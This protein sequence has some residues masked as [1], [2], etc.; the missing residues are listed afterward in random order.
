MKALRIPVLILSIFN[1]L[2][3]FGTGV[4]IWPNATTFLPM[5]LAY[6]SYP[7][8]YCMI[9]AA[10]VLA[11]CFGL[12]TWRWARRPMNAKAL[13][14]P[15][16]VLLVLN[17][18]LFFGAAACVW[19]GAIPFMLTGLICLSDVILCCVSA[20]GIIAA[21]CIALVARKKE[22][23]K[24][25]PLVL[26]GILILLCG[27][28]YLYIADGVSKT[29]FLANYLIYPGYNQTVLSSSGYIV[30]YLSVALCVLWLELA[31]IPPYLENRQ[32]L[33]SFQ[34]EPDCAN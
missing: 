23:P 30:F 20:A 5:Q 15:L 28:V 16:I 14:V 21:S 25:F 12:V 1:T 24:R 22:E 13:R 7:V 2:L 6:P 31:I 34:K 33:R 27:L 3:F 17:L 19:F 18:V 32:H 10:F 29:N 26:V 11:L 9:A 8:L 4:Y